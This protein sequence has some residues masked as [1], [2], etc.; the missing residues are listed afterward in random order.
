MVIL[1]RVE[2]LVGAPSN[3][4]GKV[5]WGLEEQGA[6]KVDLVGVNKEELKTYLDLGRSQSSYIYIYLL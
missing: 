5:S 4:P 6:F 2:A 3:L 1:P